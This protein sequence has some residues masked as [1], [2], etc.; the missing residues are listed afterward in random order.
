MILL[1]WFSENKSIYFHASGI[2]FIW[3]EREI[4]CF[5]SFDISPVMLVIIFYFIK[6]SFKEV[7]VSKW[8]GL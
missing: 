6:K 3:I 1:K 8:P 7:T 2:V 5:K 4:V